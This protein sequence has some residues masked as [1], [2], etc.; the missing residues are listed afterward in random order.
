MVLSFLLLLS[1]LFG[2]YAVGVVV[3]VYAIVV[4]GVAVDLGVVIVDCWC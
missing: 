4:V 3:V 1:Q 2:T